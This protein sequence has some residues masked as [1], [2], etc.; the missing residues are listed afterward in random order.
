[1]KKA[2]CQCADPGCT[3]EGQ[4]EENAEYLLTRVDMDDVSGTLMCDEC[5]TDAVDTGLFNCEVYQ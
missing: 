1:M 5:S 2:M 3:C 4:C